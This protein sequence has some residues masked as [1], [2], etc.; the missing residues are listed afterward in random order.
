[1]NRKRL[2]TVTVNLTIE[3]FVR[4]A[5]L[6][7]HRWTLPEPSSLMPEGT[8]KKTVDRLMRAFDRE[9][10]EGSAFR[11]SIQREARRGENSQTINKI[12]E[13]SVESKFVYLLFHSV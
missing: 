5:N 13:E 8:D 12:A 3:E 7:H 6:L 2:E 4:F 9:F 1:M 11:S 10:P